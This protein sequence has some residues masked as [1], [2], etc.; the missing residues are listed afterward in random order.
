VEIGIPG[1]ASATSAEKLDM[2][3]LNALLDMSAT[4]VAN[5]DIISKSIQQQGMR[6]SSINS[7]V[8][9]DLLID[10]QTQRYQGDGQ[11][12]TGQHQAQVHALYPEQAQ[13]LEGTMI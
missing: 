12:Q 2:D 3:C 4:T 8:R 1:L 9:T 11:P 10:Q 5:Q 6:V 13:A 7:K